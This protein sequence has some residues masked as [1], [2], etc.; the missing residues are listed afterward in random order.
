MKN[1]I[2]KRINKQDDYKTS[3]HQDTLKK[4]IRAMQSSKESQCKFQKHA[5]S[6]IESGRGKKKKPF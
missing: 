4:F 3:S 5:V 6:H 2:K 1:C